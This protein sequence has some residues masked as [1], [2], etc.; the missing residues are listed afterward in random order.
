MK[1]R[2][3]AKST[4]ENSY[5]LLGTFQR[6]DMAKIFAAAL[7]HKADQEDDPEFLIIDIVKDEVCDADPR[8][9]E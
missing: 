3:I 1:Y 2:V 5:Y 8:H 9:F 4:R 6:E 7:E